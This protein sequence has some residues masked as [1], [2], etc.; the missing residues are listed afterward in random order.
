M[1]TFYLCFISGLFLTTSCSVDKDAS[2]LVVS[3]SQ[4]DIIHAERRTPIP[5]RSQRSNLRS[6]TPDAPDVR[7][8]PYNAL[9]AVHSVGNGFIAHPLNIGNGEVININ[10][11][12]SDNITSKFMFNS[13]PGFTSSEFV[14]HTDFESLQEKVTKTKKVTSG[15]KLNLGLF[16][17][18]Q[19]TTYNKTFHS[20]IKT[21]KNHRWSNVD[22]YYYA[23]RI[24]IEKTD[25]SLQSISYRNLSDAFLFSIYTYPISNYIK[26]KGFLVV[27]D[28]FVGGRLSALVDYSST[29]NTNI[30][31]NDRDID[32]K[33]NGAFGWGPD[34]LMKGVNVAK[35]AINNTSLKIGYYK[36]NQ[37]GKTQIRNDENLFA[38]INVYGGKQSG[39]IPNSVIDLKT[40]SIDVSD[41]YESLSDPKNHKFIDVA[42]GGLVGIDKF[43]LETNF[44]YRVSMTLSGRLPYKTSL[45]IP[46]VEIRNVSGD[47]LSSDGGWELVGITAAGTILHTRQ[48][49]DIILINKD[50]QER[51]N[52]DS[53]EEEDTLRERYK[54]DTK[55][56]VDNLKKIFK[57]EIKSD[58]Y[59]YN[60]VLDRTEFLDVG[61]YVRLNFSFDK[62]KVYKYKNTKTNMWYI[63]DPEGRTALSYYD[64]PYDDDDDTFITDMY[65][66][67]D[68]VD[69]LTEKKISIKTIATS[70]RII[71]L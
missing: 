54:K 24:G 5:Q 60:K 65:G 55:S 49:D 62:N 16:S 4:G 17:I 11:L 34:S 59:N 66:L 9:G 33:I 15:F 61:L 40:A 27:T 69:S 30:E 35:D 68:W 48:G 39:K 19:H 45:D 38:R 2:I 31:N 46:Y 23:K 43:M 47:L 51:L 22:L 25:A 6:L 12:L 28:F 53:F 58:E 7:L 3:E 10:S 70:Y 14:V 18:G 44:K 67:T 8:L 21:D 52:D 64:D 56:L 37:N 50:F 13:E 29:G 71:G 36:K 57:C 26:E 42:D 20:D 32:L 1:K 41:W 63:Y